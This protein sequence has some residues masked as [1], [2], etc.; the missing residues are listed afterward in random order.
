MLSGCTVQHVLMWN[1]NSYVLVMEHSGWIGDYRFYN[2]ELCVKQKATLNNIIFL[3]ND[4]YFTFLIEHFCPTTGGTCETAHAALLSRSNQWCATSFLNRLDQA[5]EAICTNSCP[6][7]ICS[8]PCPLLLNDVL[9]NC[10][11]TVS[12][13][14]IRFPLL[15]L[16]I[17]HSSIFNFMHACT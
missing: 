6:T 15:S 17:W 2:D 5:T 12:Q 3:Q 9:E 14:N 10:N 8:T 1:I 13:Y 7:G 4:C 11:S 16:H